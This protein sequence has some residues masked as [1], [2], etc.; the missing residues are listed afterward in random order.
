VSD[1]S[2]Y[3]ESLKGCRILGI[4]PPVRD[5]AFFDLW[6][7]PMGLLYILGALREQHN[8]VNLIDCISDSS[9]VDRRY[10]RKAPKRL[11]I[12]KPEAYRGIPRRYWHFGLTREELAS[13]VHS[14]PRPDLVLVTS[15][16]TYWYKGV[17][18]CIEQLRKILP[19]VPVVLG[20]VYPVLCPDH[21]LLSGADEIQTVPMPLPVSMPAMDLYRRLSYGVAITSTGCPRRCSYCASSL[22]WPSFIQRNLRNLMAEIDLQIDLGATDLAFYDDALLI[23]KEDHFYPICEELA[24]RHPGLR[25]HTPNGLH[26][27]EIDHTCAS[28][29]YRTGF[30][31]I[32]LSLEGIDPAN[33]QAGARKT[34]PGDYSAAVANLLEA[35]FRPDQVE[36]YVLA[37]LP[38]QRAYDVASSIGFVRS[39]GARAKLAQFSP[40][41]G[42]PL[43]NE[44]VRTHPEVQEEPLLQNNTF[45]SPYVSGEITPE[46]LQSL[47]DLASTPG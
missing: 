24:A 42:T 8:H 4:N 35:G 7:K 22:L 3:L 20:G 11:E 40:I 28:T 5:F 12:P 31:T 10:G 33:R 46:E 19:G 9:S 30:R 17:F 2:G 45:Y 38:G 23:G 1:L 16:M 6:A 13:R 44:V 29:L 25:L 27:R 43:F 37:G 41:P 39:M 32:R 36:T 21:A 14:L 26:V 34:S 18:W 47:K 15:S